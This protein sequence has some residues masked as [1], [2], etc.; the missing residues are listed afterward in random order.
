MQSKPLETIRLW[1]DLHLEMSG[2]IEVADRMAESAHADLALLA[3]DIAR[4]VKGVR[5]AASHFRD[6][7]VAYVLGNHDFYGGDI[8]GTLASVRQAAVGTEMRVLEKE[9]WDVTPGLRILGTTLWTD[10]ALWGASTVDKA[11]VDGLGLNDSRRISIDGRPF[12]PADALRLHREARAWLEKELV[13]AATDG[14]RTIVLT[15]HA[16]HLSCISSEYA[17]VRDELSPSFASDL[18]DLLTGPTAPAVWCSGH[19][20]R[21]FL[22][23]VGETILLS[24]QAGYAFHGECPDFLPERLQVEA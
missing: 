20:H 3:G 18:T 6:T 17:E 21:N 13:R 14:V 11:M 2:N 15:H 16:P 24:N 4:G 19:T 8:E 10:Y 9:T 1:S 7:P 23:R 12:A 5:W 22:G